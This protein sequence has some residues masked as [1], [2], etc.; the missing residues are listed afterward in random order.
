MHHVNRDQHMENLEKEWKVEAQ[1]SIYEADFDELKQWI[2]ESAVLP[3]DRVKRGNLRWLTVAK[4]PE[5]QDLIVAYRFSTTQSDA[6]A[7]DCD[8]NSQNTAEGVD[9]N[10]GPPMALEEY[11][12]PSICFNHPDLE[13]AFVCDVCERSFCTECPKSFNVT[14]KICSVCG[15]LCRSI[16]ELDRKKRNV[17]ALNKPYPTAEAEMRR[18]GR[19]SESSSSPE[20]KFARF[21]NN[22][23]SYLRMAFRD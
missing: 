12:D 17:G 6:V 22:L 1:G 5:L 23:L 2:A 4:V 11:V 15:S 20:G 21:G 3:T 19:K 14:I 10:D 9:D 7:A 18:Q 8:F 13:V 16:K